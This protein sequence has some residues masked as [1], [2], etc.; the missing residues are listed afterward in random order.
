MCRLAVVANSSERLVGTEQSVRATE[1]LDDVLIVDDFVEVQRV[2]PFRVESCQHLVH[3]NQQIE[4][5]LAVLLYR[6][7]RTLMR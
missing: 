4:L 6:Q 2:D 3:D 5:L 7:V 1:R